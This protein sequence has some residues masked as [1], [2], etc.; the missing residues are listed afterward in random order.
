ME[1]LVTVIFFTIIS[2]SIIMRLYIMALSDYENKDNMDY[3]EDDDY[4][5]RNFQ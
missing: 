3:L 4:Y 5:K 2:V 1:L